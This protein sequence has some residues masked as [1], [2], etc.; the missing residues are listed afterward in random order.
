MRV[1]VALSVAVILVAGTLVLD[2][3]GRAQRTAGSNHV[4]TPVFSAAVP[5]GGTLCQP[6]PP[7]PAD[8]A[9]VQLLIGT[10]GRPVPALTIRYSAGS[11]GTIAE[12]ELAGGREGL[13]TIPLTYVH[14]G[15]SSIACLHVGGTTNVV[16]GGEGSAPGPHSE[17][18]DGQ[19]QPGRIG[20]N[21]LRHGR[22]SWWQL[23]SLLGTRFGLG[24]AAFMGSWTLPVLALLFV[25]MWVG[26]IRLLVK[27]LK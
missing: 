4:G 10:Y 17:V 7:I 13:V 6:A 9:E 27:E 23:L 24:K 3:S 26:A 16:L 2:L 12:G 5:G 15:T 21:Y 25:A 11:Q 18:I 20:L 8:A 19:P 22:E 14:R 1:R